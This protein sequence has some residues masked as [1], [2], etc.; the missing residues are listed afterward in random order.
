MSPLASH[1]ALASG[2]GMHVA[3]A[4]AAVQ[5][6][7]VGMIVWGAVRPGWTRVFAPIATAALLAALVL[8]ATRSPADGLA[9][10]AGATHALLY[11][12]LL[13]LFSHTLLPGHVSL[14]TQIAR[15]MNSIFHDGMY[16]YTRHV[17]A[18][19]SVFFA[20]QLLVSASL[21]LTNEGWWAFYVSTLHMP[22]VVLMAVGEYAVR[23]RR[24]RGKKLT[25]LLDTIR[26][27]THAMDTHSPPD[28]PRST[29]A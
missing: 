13:A 2:W 3:L 15:R 17:T 26:A 29:N 19:W 23:R 28:A 24:F 22:L 12:G 11:C 8:G 6:A 18:A 1:A 9:T 27:A 16:E 7:A 4:L 21:L 5:A 25:G 20:A 10:A 14:V